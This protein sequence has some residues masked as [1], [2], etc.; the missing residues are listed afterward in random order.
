M[1]AHLTNEELTNRL[2]DE[3][4]MTVDAHLLDC[5]SCRA[6]LNEMR[7][8][9]AAFRTAARGWSENA[10]TLAQNVVP[11][12]PRRKNLRAAEWIIAAAFLLLLVVMPV[13]YWQDRTSHTQTGSTPASAT[14]VFQSQ[15]NQD[16]EL[17]SAVNREIAEGVPAPMQP[18]RVS[19][20]YGTA[21]SANRTK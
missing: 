10:S 16:N 5:G 11:V 1:N 7:R 8:A 3:P 12:T 13:L 19:L 14:E 20:S 2:L 18:L 21:S 4:S 6:E 15:V 9:V 17:I